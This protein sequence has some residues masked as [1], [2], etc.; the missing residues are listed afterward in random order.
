MHPTLHTAWAN[1]KRTITLKIDFLNGVFGDFKTSSKS[2][3][4]GEKTIS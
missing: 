4:K 2:A 1:I 3:L